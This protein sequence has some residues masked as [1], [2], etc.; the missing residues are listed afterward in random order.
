MATDNHPRTTAGAIP[1]SDL[2]D[3]HEAIGRLHLEMQ[4][5]STEL[6]HLLHPTVRL[7]YPTQASE[8][9]LQSS[10]I[11]A[12][13]VN[14]SHDAI[15][16]NNL[17]NV[18]ISWN[19][20]AEKLFG[21]T[22]Q[23]VVGHTNNVVT[24]SE[25]LEEEKANVERVLQGKLHGSFET[26]AISKGGR[27]IPIS[28][29]L[30]PI[31]SSSGQVIGISKIARDIS[32]QKESIQKIL[33]I[34]NALAFQNEENSKR[35]AELVIANKSL[36]ASLMETIKLTR[37]LTELRDPYTAGHEKHVGDLAKAIAGQMGLDEI[38]QEELQIAGYLH[39]TGKIIV[40]IEILCKPSK[41]SQEEFNLVKNHVQAGYDLLKQIT[42]IWPIA[43]SV[44]EHHERLDGSGYP[45]NLK[46]D[47]ISLAG[48]ILAVA[49]VVDAMASHRPYR[50]GLGIESALAEI[51]R[52]R[53]ILF[54]PAVV[55]ACL[56]LFRE[57]AYE[58]EGPY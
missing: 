53:E 8:A 17:N 18:I 25:F 23:E 22:A 5:D 44:L 26:V 50:A 13:I 11:L 14:G 38:R 3:I 49:D 12:A 4:K 33:E 52:G 34:S 39:D 2:S 54:D 36:R 48:R 47:Q 24:P 6:G 1:A 43:S 21:Y 7:K 9:F 58:F 45:N 55:D 28:V 41:L 46:A 40:P 29:S 20:G 56:T 57:K 10:E 15:I 19:P 51:E 42:F 37:Q 27:R 31:F 16:A 32:L 35:A 30:S